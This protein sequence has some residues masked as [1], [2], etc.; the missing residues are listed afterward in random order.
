MISPRRLK[1]FAVLS[2]V[3]LGLLLSEVI[4]RLVGYH[5]SSMDP[6]MFATSST[7]YLPY[8]IKNDFHGYYAGAEFR[9][10]NFGNRRIAYA[11][12]G[13]QKK[14]VLLLGDSVV[15]GQ[16]LLDEETIGSQLQRVSLS[17]Q[18][19]FKIENVG[20]PGYS[21]WNEFGALTEY[22]AS[23]APTEVVLVYIPNDITYEDDYF[24]IGKGGRA[25]YGGIETSAQQFRRLVYSHIYVVSLAREA[26]RNLS[27]RITRNQSWS[28]DASLVT[29]ER[30]LDH[31]LEAVRRI[32]EIC[33]TKRIAFSV[34]IYRDVLFL[35][36]E[37]RWN[38][39]ERVLN[40]KMSKL[41]IKSFVI[42][43]HA[44]ELSPA[45]VRV[46]WSDPH[47]SAEAATK[48]AGD[49]L[50]HLKRQSL[51]VQTQP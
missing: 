49:I 43:S 50:Q 6:R 19:P 51:A 40:D 46:S 10:D 23:F 33:A 8:K 39:Y 1:A 29:D 22:L 9:V 44:S 15:F 16:G 26:V 14:S 41:G 24:G 36:N 25:A 37:K 11:G 20:V 18:L 38:E 48:I 12:T 47:P 42:D 7:P 2:P 5:P 27:A 32:S 28:D 3:V 13:D 21:S 34:G 35:S 17:E 30:P 31:S 4:V 45:D